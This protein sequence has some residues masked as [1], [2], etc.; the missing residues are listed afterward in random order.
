F[1]VE[2][3]LVEAFQDNVRDLVV[4][5]K[6][7]GVDEDVVKVYAHY[8]FRNEVPEDVVHHCLESGH[9]AGESDK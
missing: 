7:L 6:H 2:L 1:E 9:T 8:T 4:L 5:L 3:M